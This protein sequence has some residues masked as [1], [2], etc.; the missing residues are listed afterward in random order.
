VAQGSLAEVETLLTLCER[1]G[2]F[3]R[4]ETTLLRGLLDEAGET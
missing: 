4:E 3:P 1:I 2:W